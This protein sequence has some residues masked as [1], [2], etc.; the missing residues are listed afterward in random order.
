MR[1]R[2]RRIPVWLQRY[3]YLPGIFIIP[4]IS[5]FIDLL[6]PRRVRRDAR[7]FK[8]LLYAVY[9]TRAA[10]PAEILR[11]DAWP[12]HKLSDTPTVPA[13]RGSCTGCVPV[14]NANFPRVRRGYRGVEGT[15]RVARRSRLKETSEIYAA[16]RIIGYDLNDG[17]TGHYLAR[18][19]HRRLCTRLV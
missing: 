1:Y 12:I 18:I 7:L 13:E 9:Y 6:V 15:R 3:L 19:F 10:I 8:R 14:K 17:F 2:T 5:P 16:E 4:L 11:T